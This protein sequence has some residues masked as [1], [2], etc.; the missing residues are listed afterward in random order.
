MIGFYGAIPFQT[1][2]ERAKAAARTAVQLDDKLSEAHTSAMR[3]SNTTG[4]GWLRK[5]NTS[6]PST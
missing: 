6:V 4:I 3:R 1:A 2:F 5:Q